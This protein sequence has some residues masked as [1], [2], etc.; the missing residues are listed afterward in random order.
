M[1][2]EK[3]EIFL[4]LLSEVNDSLFMYARALV[5]N[6]KDAEDLVQ[7]SIIATYENFESLR[8]YSCFKG[9]IFKVARSKYIQKHR[10]SWLFGKYEADSANSLISND[11]TPDLPL[12]IETLYNALNKLPE[13][14]KESLVLFEISGFS[15]EEICEI[16]SSSLPAVKSRLK[17]AREK[18]SMILKSEY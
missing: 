12:E 10:R 8:N 13:N 4:K 18:L 11:F 14:Q 17:R 15:I 7:D 3:Q 2:K 9:Y 6:N 5:K 1:N 16:Q